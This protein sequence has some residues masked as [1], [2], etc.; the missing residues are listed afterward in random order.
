MHALPAPVPLSK[1][2]LLRSNVLAP[3]ALI[4]VTLPVALQAQ[5]SGRGDAFGRWQPTVRSC[6]SVEPG[7]VEQSCQA[8]LVDQRGSGVFRIRWGLTA[9]RQLAFVGILSDRSE[10]MVCRQAVCRLQRPITLAI[11]GV[12]SNQ[13]VGSGGVSS[14]PLV[15]SARGQC[16]LRADQLRCEAQALTGERWSIEA[17]LR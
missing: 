4:L 11:S 1:A 14:L 16:R 8:V 7:Q 3:V 6:R 15:W 12:S 10:P 13:L 17:Q 2:L 5:P 9:L